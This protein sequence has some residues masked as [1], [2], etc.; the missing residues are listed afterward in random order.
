MHTRIR[1]IQKET[2]LVSK[3]DFL[4]KEQIVYAQIDTTTMSY[5]L[6]AR[7]KDRGNEK[8]VAQ[9]AAKTLV[10]VKKHVKAEL[11]GL[12]VQ[13]NEEVRNKVDEGSSGENLG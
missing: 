1:Y 12:G 6:I 5:K 2:L 4:A 10:E 7:D 11:K 8:I 3:D 9:G 13:F